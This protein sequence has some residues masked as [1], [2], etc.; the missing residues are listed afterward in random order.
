[1][2]QNGTRLLTTRTNAFDDELFFLH[3]EAFGKSDCGDAGLV[4]AVCRAATEAGEVDVT[5]MLAVLASA[6]AV[7][8]MSRSVVDFVKQL[9]AD[10]QAKR[11]KDAGTI[12]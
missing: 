3:D 12:H 4:E 5:E 10:E 7:F 8:L 11:A 6:D 1:M 9:C 2:E